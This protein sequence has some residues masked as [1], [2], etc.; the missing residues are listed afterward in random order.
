MKKSFVI[1]FMAIA[2]LANGCANVSLTSKSSNKSDEKSKLDEKSSFNLFSLN[3]KQSSVKIFYKDGRLVN[4]T[5]CEGV[6]W[7]GCFSE[8]GK[9]CNDLG[10]DILEK[11]I[12]KESQ[13]FFGEKDVRELYYICK[14][15]FIEP[16][17]K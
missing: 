16:G 8:A 5:K 13:I 12:S 14:E 4:V 1:Y 2:L 6:T 10:Y 11:N 7:L 15:P 17:Q 3:N 9:I